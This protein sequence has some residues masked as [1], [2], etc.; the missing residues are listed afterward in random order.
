[1]AVEVDQGEGLIIMVG[2]TVPALAAM[3]TEMA[4]ANLSM[5]QTVAGVTNQVGEDD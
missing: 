3:V 2:V 5:V 1:M 4:L